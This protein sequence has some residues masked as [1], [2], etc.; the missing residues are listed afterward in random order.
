MVWT[1][2]SVINTRIDQIYYENT[3]FYTTGA[4]IQEKL[5]AGPGFTN[6]IPCQ[7]NSCLS[8]HLTGIIFLLILKDLSAENFSFTGLLSSKSVVLDFEGFRYKIKNLIVKELCVCTEDLN[9]CVLLS[10]FPSVKNHR[11]TNSTA[12]NLFLLVHKN[13]HGLT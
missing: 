6:M 1:T 10:P 9:D 3:I 11:I 7:R 13:I 5:N 2:V 8:G 4:F 12:E